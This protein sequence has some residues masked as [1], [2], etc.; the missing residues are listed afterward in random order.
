MLNNLGNS[1]EKAEACRPDPEEMLQN[2]RKRHEK[3][4]K[5]LEVVKNLKNIDL[6][7]GEKAEEGLYILIGKLLAQGWEYEKEI[8]Y[9][10][11]ECEK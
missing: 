9:W 7:I 5:D 1:I 11:K 2:I 4:Q 6:Y 8:E 10:L 3:N